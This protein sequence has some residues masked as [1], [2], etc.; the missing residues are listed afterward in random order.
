MEY[1][2]IVLASTKSG[3]FPNA[4]KWFTK[5]KFSHSLV[6]TPD[7]LEVPMCIEAGAAGVDFTRFDKS[8]IEN[9]EQT[10][11]VWKVKAPQQLKDE[12]IK[13]LLNE[14]EVGYGYLEYGY[15]IWRRINLLFGRDIKSQNNWNTVGMICSE[16]CVA[17]LKA[18]GLEKVLAGYG[19][20]SIAPQDLQNIFKANPQL[21]ELVEE[22]GSF[23]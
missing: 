21:F 12:A 11:Q 5:S 8:Y 3:F 15:F 6:T 23:A 7:I 1:G 4:I 18:V 17:Y 2:H 20:G 14:L 9:P 22:K 16:L 13:L 19:E 10:Y